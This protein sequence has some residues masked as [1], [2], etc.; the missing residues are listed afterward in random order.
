MQIG[1]KINQFWLEFDQYHKKE[2]Q[3]G[4]RDHIWNS[5]D[6]QNGMSHMWHSR[7]SLRYTKV[8]GQL[9]CRVTSK[10]LGTGSAERNWGD[11]KHLK[12]N[13]QAHLSADRV[14]KQATIFGSYCMDKSDIKRQFSE[15]E[16]NPYLF[17]N[18]EDFD[19]RFDIL[20]NDNSV[21][22]MK[23]SRIFKCWEEEWEEEAI[24]L[25]SPVNE[26]KLLNKYGGLSWFDIDNDQMVYSDKN[27]LKWTRVTRSKKS[28]EKNGGYSL[29]VYDEYYNKDKE[30]YNDHMEPWTFLVDLRESIGEYYE[31]HPE[32]GIKVL[33]LEETNENKSESESDDDEE[34]QTKKKQIDETKYH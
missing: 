20:S 5:S 13:K 24:F 9:A 16:T 2:G 25:K 28:E 3:F 12:T 27:D 19:W 4:N 33:R 14:K 15:N 1:E 7:N 26:A 6:I 34:P 8:L 30:D 32:L 29:I 10:I 21:E 11:V 17:W 23:P 18:D 22:E 31:K